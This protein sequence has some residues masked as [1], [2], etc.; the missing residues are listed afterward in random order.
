MADRLLT[1]TG[2]YLVSETVPGLSGISTLN[3][4][5]V[6]EIFKERFTTDPTAS[7]WLYGVE[8]SW[9][10]GNGNMQAI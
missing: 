5:I 9:N 7:G 10:V 3:D 4:S 2:D 8:W 6:Y 1:E